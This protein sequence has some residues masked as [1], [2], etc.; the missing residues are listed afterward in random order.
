MWMVEESGVPVG[1][2]QCPVEFWRS[3]PL[4]GSGFASWRNI[5]ASSARRPSAQYLLAA[6]LVT[7]TDV[8]TAGNCRDQRTRRSPTLA[9][10]SLP[11]SRREKPLAVSRIDCSLSRFDLKRGGVTFGPLRLPVCE[12]K[13]FR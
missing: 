4:S 5:A 3:R 1:M 2:K 10:Y 13:K 12:E 8:G 6:F 7:V 9:T 11:L